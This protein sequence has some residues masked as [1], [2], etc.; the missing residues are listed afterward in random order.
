MLVCLSSCWCSLWRRCC[1][2]RELRSR[3]IHLGKPTVGQFPA[4]TI[5]NQKY[6]I[7]TFL[8]LVLYQ[9]FKFFLNL[10]F[11]VMATSQFVPDIRIGYLYTYWGP[12]VSYFLESDLCCFYFRLVH[13]S[14]LCFLVFCTVGNDLPR[15]RRRFT[16][17]Q[18]RS[19]GKQPEM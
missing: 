3:T 10:Y 1:G 4:N 17:T 5:R 11:L 18:E 9:Q 13:N 14:F 2:P 16:A 7:I 19:G 15:S 6:N 8:P 12:L